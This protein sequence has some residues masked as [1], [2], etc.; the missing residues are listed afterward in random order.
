M[1][2]A[3][4]FKIHSYWAIDFPITT[5]RFSQYLIVIST[6]AK[7]TASH[8]VLKMKAANFFK[9]LANQPTTSMCQDHAK[10]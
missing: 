4:N 5:H 10:I 8:S 2:N 1:L 3:F 7:H 9:M 6:V